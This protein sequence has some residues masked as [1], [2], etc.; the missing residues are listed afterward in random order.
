L[1]SRWALVHSGGHP[2][3][4]EG[5]RPCHGRGVR[6]LAD[7]LDLIA[8]P[9]CLSCRGRSPA[10]LCPA[11]RA[12]ADGLRLTATCVRCA[13]SPGAGHPCWRP[14]APIHATVAAFRYAGAIADAV[15]AAKVLG[16]WAAWPALGHELARL[17]RGLDVDAVT[18]VPA[19]TRTRRRRGFDHARLLAEAVARSLDVPALGVL[20]ARPRVDQASRTLAERRRVAPDA[21]RAT[22]P[23]PPRLLLVDDVVTT[24]AT[25]EVAARASG[26]EQVT[27]AVLARAG[28]HPLGAAIEARDRAAGDVGSSR[29]RR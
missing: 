21:F 25:A 9:R 29:T 10:V 1:R 22:R 18:W 28:A 14:G 19:D 2:I 23:A 7:L 17:T 26:A 4:A 16:A 5:T 15:V 11:C 13:G 3:V 24:G 12:R 27:L 20:E 6:P 8:P